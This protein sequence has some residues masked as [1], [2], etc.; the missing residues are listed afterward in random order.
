MLALALA[1]RQREGLRRPGGAGSSSSH[2]SSPPLLPRGNF[3]H[4]TP[5]SQCFSWV[6]KRSGSSTAEDNSL[7]PTDT[8]TPYNVSPHNGR[9]AAAAD[10]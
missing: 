4:T 10:G 8:M 9:L 3:P 5:R 6:R 2:A 1:L 7:A